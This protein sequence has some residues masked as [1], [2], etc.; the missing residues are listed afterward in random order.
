MLEMADVDQSD[1][2]SNKG[3][4]GSRETITDTSGDITMMSGSQ[5]SDAR[6]TRKTSGPGKN[7][8]HGSTR[9]DVVLL[10]TLLTC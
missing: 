1:K 9:F 10:F 3:D 8:N 5:I 4:S 2:P 6:A 7:L